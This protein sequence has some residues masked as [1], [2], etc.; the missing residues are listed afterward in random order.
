M[1]PEFPWLS[2]YSVDNEICHPI[3]CDCRVFKT[4]AELKVMRYAAQ[5]AAEGH[6]DVMK[7][8]KPGLIESY[9]KSKFLA[10]GFEN[11]NINHSPYGE[12]L[13]SGINSATL[14]YVVNDKIIEKG[15]FVL[16]DCGYKVFFCKI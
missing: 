8:C 3:L 7:N 15:E 1:I 16:C 13:A 5:A 6:V 2:K 9:L 4:E 12:I 14:H 11:Y 10:Y